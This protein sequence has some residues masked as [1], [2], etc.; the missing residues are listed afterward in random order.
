MVDEKRFEHFKQN[1]QGMED[2]FNE[3]KKNC[4]I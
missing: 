2:R 3:I 4:P 1:L